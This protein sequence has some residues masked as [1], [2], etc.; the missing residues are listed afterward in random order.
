MSLFYSDRN[1]TVVDWALVGQASNQLVVGNPLTRREQLDV[2]SKFFHA[3]DGLYPT[4]VPS[5]PKL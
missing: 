5:S 4:S 2:G 1:M 3:L